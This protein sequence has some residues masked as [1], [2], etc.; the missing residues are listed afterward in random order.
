MSQK[1]RLTR[2][3][4]ERVA[5]LAHLGLTDE[6]KEHLQRDLSLILE[7][8]DRLREVLTEGVEPT[9]HLVPQESVLRPDTVR[10]SLPQ[11]QVLANAPETRD[12]FFRV[13]RILEES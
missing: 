11:G 8:F 9:T 6:E 3:D 13:P 1:L 7:A 5:R 4:V 12:G 10:P 2:E